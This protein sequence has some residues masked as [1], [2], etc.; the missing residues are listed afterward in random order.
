MADRVR[1]PVWDRPDRGIIRPFLGAVF[2]TIA[3]LL[4]AACGA[5]TASSRDGGSGR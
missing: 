1:V 3:T 4:A 2:T 5:L